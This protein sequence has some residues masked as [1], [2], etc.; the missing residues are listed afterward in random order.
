MTDMS[1][2]PMNMPQ[3]PQMQ[4]GMGYNSQQSALLNALMNPGMSSMAAPQ[5]SFNA[6]STNTQ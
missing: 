6:P 5:F 2:A 4:Q 1:Q 3:M